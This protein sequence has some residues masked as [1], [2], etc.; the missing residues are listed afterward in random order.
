M[1]RAKKFLMLS[2]PVVGLLIAT[3]FGLKTACADVVFSPTGISPATPS[4][5][6]SNT[7]GYVGYSTGAGTVAITSGGTSSLLASQNGCIGYDSSGTGTVSVDGAGSTW[8]N[9]QDLYVGGNETNASAGVLTISNGGSV[10]NNGNGRI[11]YKTGSSGTV[12]VESGGTWDQ[13]GFSFFVG[14]Y[15]GGSLDINSGG[16]VTNRMGQ[17]G[18]YSTGRGTVSV[19]GIGST[20]SNSSGIVVASFGKGELIV[21]DGGIV[22][23]VGAST[24]AFNSGSAGT[25]TVDGSGS[26]WT[27][28][29]NFNTGNLYVGNM[30]YGKLRITN[31]GTVNNTRGSTYVDCSLSSFG[32][33]IF[34]GNGGTLN[35]QSLYASTSNLTG[36]GTIHTRGLVGDGVNL[37][38]DS[39]APKS[40]SITGTG[41]NISVTLNASVSSD[42]GD[43]G[44]GYWGSSSLTIQNGATVYS[45]A[46]RLGYK[47]G[48]S[49][50]A[51][52]GAGSTWDNAESLF[53]GQSGTGTLS[54]TGGTVVSH[55]GFIADQSG[56]TGQVTIAGTGS[57]W[58]NS[59]GLCV[60]TGG[61]G[62]LSITGGGTVISGDNSPYSTVS[63]GAEGNAVGVVTVDGIGSTLIVNTSLYVGSRAK[64][65]LKIINAG[66]VVNANYATYIGWT[67]A[68]AGSSSIDFD[69]GGGTLTTKSLYAAPT[70][71]TGSGTVET[72]GLVGDGFHLTFDSGATKSIALTDAG[73]NVTVTVDASDSATAGDL[74]AGYL[75]NDSLT[76]QNASAVYSQAGY[77]GYS[78]GSSGTAT[79]DGTGSQWT[80][81]GDL[82]VGYNGTGMLQITGGGTVN[83]VKGAI[84]DN[85]GA[86]GAVTVNGH[87]STWNN[88]GDLCVGRSGTGTLNVTGGGDVTSETGYIGYR[89]GACGTVTV[90]G[91]GSTWT[92]TGLIYVGAEGPR[93]G[94]TAILNIAD[95]GVVSAA[96]VMKTAAG[97]GTVT[98]DGGTLKALA[99]SSTFMT[100]LTDVFIKANGAKFDTNGHAIEINQTLLTDA[101]STGGGLTK[102][103]TGTL[104]LSG[105]NTYDGPTTVEAGTLAL[106]GFDTATP[107]AWDAVLTGGGADIQSGKLIFNY[108]GGT[109]PADTIAQIL[110]DS[111]GT[112]NPFSQGNGAQI[113]SSTADAAGKALGWVDDGVNEEVTVMYT[114]YGDSNLDGSVNGTD[115]NAVLS[116]YNQSSQIWNHGDFNYDGSVNGTDLNTVLSNYNQSLSSSTAAVPEPSTLLLAAVAAMSLLVWRRRTLSTRRVV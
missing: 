71:F 109:S 48:A 86:V 22:N 18:N 4:S 75:G 9:S 73:R 10:V 64:G 63:I 80:N 99:A 40:F 76:I 101:V 20:W 85:G 67:Q 21:T 84:S 110:D 70:Q 28:S 7:D 42:V 47:A 96:G 93:S 30:G 23:S 87:G 14:G 104:T 103:G 100:G 32:S 35:T 62:T 19:D 60:G 27:N 1:S 13:S 37:V 90:S 92:N 36:T 83:N 58:T 25:V 115:L 111:F 106:V 59:A 116:Y 45:K 77:L 38:F 43:M 114:L 55:G 8:T 97:T 2:L 74:G 72:R 69:T 57:R 91:A 33:N 78:T 81:V 79:V 107:S 52:V 94:G 50:S 88:S 11:A 3:A 12:T 49:G 5:W 29:A 6:N 53:V 15:G 95:D 61:T 82:S 68:S 112:S 65:T 56:S 98:F 108:A 39:T 16:T 54:V 105:V 113:Y 17:I 41:K 89:P 66:T 24:I 102:T 51:T 26:T 44:A 46:G 34:F 31:G